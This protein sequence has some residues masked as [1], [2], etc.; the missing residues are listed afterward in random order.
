MK[1]VITGCAGYIGYGLADLLA[2]NEKVTSV[3]L[4]DNLSRQN[5]AVF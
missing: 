2:A 5:D 1:V 4:Y 3:L